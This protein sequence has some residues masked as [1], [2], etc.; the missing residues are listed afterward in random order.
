[1]KEKEI[2]VKKRGFEV[3]WVQLRIQ[4]YETSNTNEMM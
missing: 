2:K 3:Q 1:M 4:K